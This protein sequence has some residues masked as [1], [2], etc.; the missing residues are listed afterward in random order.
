MIQSLSDCWKGCWDF[1]CCKE[2]PKPRVL[3]VSIARHE[4]HEVTNEPIVQT[5]VVVVVRP[6]HHLYKSTDIVSM[7]QFFKQDK[8]I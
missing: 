8:E 1:I 4:P 5:H 2:K 6:G 7:I 3:E